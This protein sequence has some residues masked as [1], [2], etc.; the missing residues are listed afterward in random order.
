M[1]A[2]FH[3]VPDAQLINHLNNGVIIRDYAS[4]IN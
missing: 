4:I 2:A 1:P 3:P